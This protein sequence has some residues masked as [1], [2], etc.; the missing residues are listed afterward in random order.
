MQVLHASALQVSHTAAPKQN[1][2]EKLANLKQKQTLRKR[3]YED[4]TASE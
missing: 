4:R 2:V 3:L 1:Y